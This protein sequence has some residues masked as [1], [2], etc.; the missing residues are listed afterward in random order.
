MKSKVKIILSVFILVLGFV[1]MQAQKGQGRQQDPV[2]RAEKQTAMLTEK[3]SLTPEQAAKVKEINLRYA[4]KQQAMKGQAADGGGEKNK[5]AFQQMHKDRQAEINEVLNKDQQAQFEKLQSERKDR[6]SDGRKAGFNGDPE[7]Q[8][9]QMTQHMT[10]NL[11]LT[12]DQVASVKAINL[13]FA[14]KMQT[15]R[16]E[17]KEGEKPDRSAMKSLHEDHKA[18]LE[19]V[20]T[21]EQIEKM[22]QMKK[23]RKHDG[24]GKM[25][26]QSRGM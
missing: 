20:L 22:G 26:G 1:S 12:P 14:K 3:L 8:A 13:D 11:S 6:R 16:G 5:A 19:K 18:A 24:K 2:Q 4:E 25:K 21:K 9:E 23:E 10:E 17:K 7:K 15:I